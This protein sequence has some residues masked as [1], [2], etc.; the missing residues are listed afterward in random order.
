IGGWGR[1]VRAAVGTLG[2]ALQQRGDPLTAGGTDRDQA[3]DRC[4][5]AVRGPTVPGGA[6]VQQPGE[7]GGDAG[8][9]GGEGVPGGEGGTGDVQ[10]LRGDPPQRPRQAQTSLAEVRVRPGGQGREYL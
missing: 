10:P 8:A 4:G 2:S 1:S 5:R 6:L 3:T 7:C 9:G